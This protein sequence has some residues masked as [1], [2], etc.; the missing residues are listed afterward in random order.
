M[1]LSETGKVGIVCLLA[2]TCVAAI[3]HCCYMVGFILLGNFFLVLLKL[4]IMSLILIVL[5]HFKERVTLHHVL[6]KTGRWFGVGLLLWVTM[7]SIHT[8][9]VGT[10]FTQF[11]AFLFLAW[12]FIAIWHE[13]R[14]FLRNRNA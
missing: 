8:L 14:N 7:V 9:Q 3:C 10:A 11:L 2:T 6:K 4:I 12:L 5:I 1:E 13:G